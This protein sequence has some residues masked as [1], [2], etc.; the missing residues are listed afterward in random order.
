MSAIQVSSEQYTHN[1]VQS[2][3]QKQCVTLSSSEMICISKKIS[4][5]F[6]SVSRLLVSIPLMARSLCLTYHCVF[7]SFA[8]KCI[9]YAAILSLSFELIAYTKN[10]SFGYCMH[11]RGNC[12]LTGRRMA[13]NQQRKERKK[14]KKKAGEFALNWK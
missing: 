11:I 10:A 3:K 2:K 7:V 5:F 6:F 1:T 12:I 14:K 13:S 8:L 9:V 4:Q